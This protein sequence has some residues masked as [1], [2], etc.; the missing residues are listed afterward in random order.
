MAADSQ[1]ESIKITLDD[2]KD[3]STPDVAVP[4]RPIHPPP[5]EPA[6]TEIS[7]VAVTRLLPYPKLRAASFSKAGSIWGW[8]DFSVQS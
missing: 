4:N 2:L 1:N 3:V 5:R 6:A 7:A 8:Q